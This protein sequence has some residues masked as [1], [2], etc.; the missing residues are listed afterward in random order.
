PFIQ[1]FYLAQHIAKTAGRFFTKLRRVRE[2]K[3]IYLVQLEEGDGITLALPT[4]Y[5]DIREAR[6]WIIIA[7]SLD[8][9][10]KQ[11]SLKLL[12]NLEA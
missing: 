3:G 7:T 5:S 1:N 8:L 10:E 4:R 9:K 12:E 6:A 2:A 11:M